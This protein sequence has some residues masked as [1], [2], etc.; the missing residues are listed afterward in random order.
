VSVSVQPAASAAGFSF[1][2]RCPGTL[3]PVGKTLAPPASELSSSPPPAKSATTTAIAATA[4][5]AAK[6]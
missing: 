2:A 5:A 4:S 6:P 1:K 3:P